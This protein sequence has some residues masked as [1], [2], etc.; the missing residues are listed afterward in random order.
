MTVKDF[1][2]VIF[3][4]G[5]DPDSADPSQLRRRRTLSTT[6]I[7]LLPLAVVLMITNTYLANAP[8]ENFE[9]GLVVFVA[10][11]G[12]YVQ[13][14]KG[15]ERFASYSLVFTFWF[16]SVSVMYRT[17]ISSGNWTW[18]LPGVLLANL[19]ANRKV[20]TVYTLVSVGTLIS[21]AVMSNA[22]I[23]PQGLTLEEHGLT[24]AT[25]GSMGLC[26]M[27]VLGYTF[28]TIQNSTEERLK[29]NLLRL[30]QEVTA[31][32]KAEQ[33]AR[34]AQ[35]T[36]ADFLATVSHELR[37]PL[38]GVLGA[39][40]LLKN[41][42]LYEAEQELIDTVNH[43]G[44]LLL[45]LINNVLDLSRLEAGRLELEHTDF[46][47]ET[48]V[49]S[50]VA[51]FKVLGRG[52]SV[53]VTYHIDDCVPDYLKGDPTRIR[54]IIFNLCGK[55]VRS[56]DGP[57]VKVTV[58]FAN[59]KLVLSVAEIGTEAVRQNLVAPMA[60]LPSETA[61][62]S[63]VT[64]SID[65]ELSIVE[66]LV[67][68]FD[69]EIAVQSM[70]DTVSTFTVSLPIGI[71]E[72]KTDPAST[73]DQEQSSLESNLTVLLTD[74]NAINRKVVSKMLE[75][76]GCVVVEAV[77]GQQALTELCNRHIDVVL[78]DVNMPVMDGL[79]ATSRIRDMDEPICDTPIIGLTAN[80][81]SSV[82]GNLIAA[83]MDDALSKPVKLE[84]LRNALAKIGCYA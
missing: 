5:L 75:H 26:I 45:D 63:Q 76:L 25:V 2:L 78:M 21:F 79:T 80:A 23:L 7:L 13:A 17:G 73:S 11:V 3:N 36:K 74:D 10:L 39:G 24:V 8:D 35:K 38:N 49:Y 32:H 44:D 56:T 40:H 50:A 1:L 16:A 58:A 83:G 20:A 6:W 15:W 51:P 31:R 70:A 71:G 61:K 84:T 53:E 22:E 46:H 37:T 52:K 18:L 69:G 65:L 14:F 59:N 57:G 28:R 66:E 33:E 67:A 9:V 34:A 29:A 62:S 72:N 27:T 48:I 77:D 41:T 4:G 30:E 19:I 12:L 42:Q 60:K 54:Q 43:S 64:D 81:L 68:L 82:T 47:V 55:V